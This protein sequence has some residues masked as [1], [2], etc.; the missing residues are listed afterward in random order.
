MRLKFH[1]DAL[2]AACQC[3][4]QPVLE[5]EKLGR[6]DVEGLRR[7]LFA[8]HKDIEAAGATFTASERANQRRR[9][10]WIYFKPVTEPAF[11]SRAPSSPFEVTIIGILPLEIVVAFALRLVEVY[12]VH[13]AALD[14]PAP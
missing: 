3:L 14:L 11:A 4:R 1:G 2:F 10:L 5:I 8:V 6:V 13:S 9:L 12:R 7:D